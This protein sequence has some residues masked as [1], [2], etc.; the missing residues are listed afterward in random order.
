MVELYE[1]AYGE[2]VAKPVDV[3]AQL[4]EARRGRRV[5]KDE[6]EGW[7]DAI[8]RDF[9]RAVSKLEANLRC[10]SSYW[11]RRLAPRGGRSGRLR[12]IVKDHANKWCC[13]KYLDEC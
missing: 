6:K 12:K 8:A 3:L 1:D 7:R 2:D 9:F 5:K 13:L 10:P 11:R 4:V